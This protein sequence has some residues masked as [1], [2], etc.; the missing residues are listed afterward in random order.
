[1]KDRKK[2][3]AVVSQQDVNQLRVLPFQPPRTKRPDVAAVM[4][5]A[6]PGK[7]VPLYYAPLLREDAASGKIRVSMT[8]QET[9]ELLVNDVQMDVRAYCI[10]FSAFE[11]FEGSID[12]FNRS[13]NGQPQVDG[14]AVVPFFQTRTMDAYG[15]NEIFTTLGIHAD[16]AS[17][18]NTAIEEA[19]NLLVNFRRQQLSNKLTLRALNDTTLA[20]AFWNHDQM[21]HIKPSFDQAL[22]DGELILN[23]EDLKIPVKGIFSDATPGFAST[24]DPTLTETGAAAGQHGV[25]TSQVYLEEDP[26][27]LGFPG[28]FA[29][30]AAGGL[31]ATLSNIEQAK[32]T[33]AFARLRTQFRGHTDDWIIDQLMSGISIPEL[34]LTQPFLLAKKKVR[35]SQMQRYATD[36]PSLSV[37]ANNGFASVDLNIRVPR[38]HSGGIV[39][40][41][42]EV[43]PTQL[44]ERQKDTFFHLG[45]VAE[46]PEFQRDYLDPE[47]VEI[48]TNDFVDVDHGTPNG[49][50]GYSF[51]N[52]SWKRRIP[53]IGG[54]YYRPQVDAATDTDRQ[55]FWANEGVDPVLDDDFYL[56]NTLHKK[57]F[58]DP[59]SEP[60]EFQVTGGLMITGNTHFGPHIIEAED[61]YTDTKALV[62][63]TRLSSDDVDEANV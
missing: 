63:Q 40:V 57:V 41:T 56:V 61:E 16:P 47:P 13:Y 33:A 12:Q 32:K 11:R 50:F 42:A 3:S 36:G 7:I 46:L 25:F 35:V 43:T 23:A 24:V 5:S 29:E 62:D 14:G 45:T 1:M 17:T 2:Q 55:R 44:F 9:A 49:V 48:V 8:L 26:S 38:I 53:R 31:T 18:I 21:R 19:Y 6:D 37:Q 54:K 52:H 27:N 59:A 58:V 4:T 39:L 28:V 15:T 30:M 20:E 22:I 34:Y 60:C 10:P 51:L